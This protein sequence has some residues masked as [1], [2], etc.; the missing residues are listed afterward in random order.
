VSDFD[1]VGMAVR[2]SCAVPGVF[3]PVEIRDMRLLD[4]GVVDQVP[5]DVVAAMGADVKVGISL[6]M[7][8]MPDKVTSFTAAIA[9]TIGIMG[10]RQIRAGL[11][12]A[13][14]AVRI[15]GI[16]K[17]SAV[18]PHQFDLVDLGERAMDGRLED[19][20][21]VAGRRRG[22]TTPGRAAQRSPGG[23][24]YSPARNSR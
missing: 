24:R 11:D 10:I 6:G 21:R 1:D 17:R 18:N 8:Y 7:V 9:A 12:M 22:R 14:V 5:V 23:P 2:A 15:E 4:G 20:F 19:L 13:D 3:R 16:E